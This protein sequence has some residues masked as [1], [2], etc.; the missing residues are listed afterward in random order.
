MNPAVRHLVDKQRSST[1]CTRLSVATVSRVLSPVC[2]QGDSFFGTRDRGS[3]ACRMK[4]KKE[5]QPMRFGK[6]RRVET[7]GETF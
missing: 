2:V 4:V 1:P 7:A 3:R 6:E 5:K